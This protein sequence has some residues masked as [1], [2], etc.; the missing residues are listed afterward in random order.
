VEPEEEWDRLKEVLPALCSQLHIPISLDTRHAQVAQRGIECGVAI[1]NDVSCARDPDL[2]QL[3]AASGVGYVLMHSRGDSNDMMEWAKYDQVEVE[4]FKELNKALKKC[5]K[6]KIN[7]EKICIDPGFGFAK[8]P[9]DSLQLFRKLE[10]FKVLDYPLLV[11]VS[12]KRMIRALVGSSQ[13]ALK[14][15]SVEAA[16]IAVQNG[17]NILRV[18]DVGVTKRTMRTFQW[19]GNEVDGRIIKSKK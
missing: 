12:R 2:L 17:A 16:L 19:A 8:T 1:I 15:G 7:K 14:K 10:I 3:V 6:Y 5:F 9:Q 4:V 13:E 11:G 18:H